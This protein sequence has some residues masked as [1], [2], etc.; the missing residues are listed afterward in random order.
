MFGTALFIVTVV[1]VVASV[2][3]SAACLILTV[4]M[5]YSLK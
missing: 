2:G 3:A 1:L 4:H 5:I